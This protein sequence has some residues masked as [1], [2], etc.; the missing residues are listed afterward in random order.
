MV[1]ET[2]DPYQDAER[3]HDASTKA[4]AA[5][6]DDNQATADPAREDAREEEDP[7]SDGGDSLRGYAKDLRG[8]LSDPSGDQIPAEEEG[9]DAAAENEE[10]R[11]GVPEEGESA[12]DAAP[13]G[14]FNVGSSGQEGGLEASPSLATTPSLMDTLQETAG[15]WIDAGTSPSLTV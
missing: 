4:F 15:S 13:A 5:S 7:A 6:L 14:I 2:I 9:R 10:G 11:D 12:A 1:L 3:A 8:S